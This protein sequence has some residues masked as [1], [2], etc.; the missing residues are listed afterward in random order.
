MKVDVIDIL[1]Q[2]RRDQC[3]PEP[4]SNRA[5]DSH[6]PARSIFQSLT[7]LQAPRT[8][9]LAEFAAAWRF[10]RAFRGSECGVD[11][12]A[13]DFGFPINYLARLYPSHVR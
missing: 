5:E 7:T 9:S 1:V 8:R 6:Q 3:G 12:F 13:G 4:I 10:K 2:P 11:D